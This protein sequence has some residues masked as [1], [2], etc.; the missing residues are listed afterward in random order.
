MTNVK[1]DLTLYKELKKVKSEFDKEVKSAK[2]SIN[3]NNFSEA[4]TSLSKCEGYINN[5]ES[6]IDK[7]PDKSTVDTA[8]KTLFY[9]VSVLTGTVANIAYFNNN[10]SKLNKE[11]ESIVDEYNKNERDLSKTKDKL[12]ENYKQHVKYSVFFNYWSKFH[13]NDPSLSRAMDELKSEIKELDK[14][15]SKLTD[16]ETKIE[17]NMNKNKKEYENITKKIKNNEKK[18]YG[19]TAASG[20]G[21][22]I[23]TASIKTLKQKA[24]NILKKCNKILANTKAYLDKVEKMSNAVKESFDETL[25]SLYEAFTEGTIDE[26]EYDTLMDHLL[27]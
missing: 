2:S 20:I 1:Q 7:L 15:F 21:I 6:I 8:K 3:R 13:K 12:N 27:N 10:D 24:K 9:I 4:K 19:L 26:F 18:S 16:D 11:K 25:D 22:G 23:A 17:I 5:M 14:E